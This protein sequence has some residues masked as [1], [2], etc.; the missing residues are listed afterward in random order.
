MAKKV[1]KKHFV[2]PGWPAHIPG[3]GHYVTELVNKLSGASSPFGDD[4]PFP[5]PAEK[6]GYVHPYTN[7][8]GGPTVG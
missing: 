8:N 7:I 2:D 3:D 4:M 6:T 1:E 5:L